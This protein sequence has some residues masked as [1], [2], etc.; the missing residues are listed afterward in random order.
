MNKNW[1]NQHEKRK[2]QELISYLY[3]QNAS[4]SID[5]EDLWIEILKNQ[6]NKELNE[7]Q[8]KEI[9]KSIEELEEKSKIVQNNLALLNEERIELYKAYQNLED[10]I[11]G[12]YKQLIEEES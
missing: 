1:N 11:Y 10:D 6:A 9:E 7:L 5:K 2:R 8:A 4:I 12:F 3:E